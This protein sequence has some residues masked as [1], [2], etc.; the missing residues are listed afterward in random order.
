MENSRHTLFVHLDGLQSPK[1]RLASD[2]KAPAGYRQLTSSG[3]DAFYDWLRSGSG[4]VIGVRYS[5]SSEDAEKA[6]GR[7][8]ERAY[9]DKSKNGAL[10]IFFS[11]RR[12][13][14]TE[15][16]A[17]QAFGGSEIFVNRK[18]DWLMSFDLY[19]L[20]TTEMDSLRKLAK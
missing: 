15:N 20:T 11:Q 3:I 13:Y 5:P 14:S 16:S 2:P 1:L 6:I 4:A 18:H 8:P 9:V 19:S 7:F 10:E 12:D 17:D